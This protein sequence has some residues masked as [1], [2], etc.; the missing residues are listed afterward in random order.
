MRFKGG[1]SA[2][3][4][5]TASLAINPA[6][7]AGLKLALLSIQDDDLDLALKSVVS[8]I[9]RSPDMLCGDILGTLKSGADMKQGLFSVISEIYFSLGRQWDMGFQKHFSDSVPDTAFDVAL[10][11]WGSAPSSW[12]LDMMSRCLAPW[13]LQGELT[14]LML[15]GIKAGVLADRQMLEAAEAAFGYYDR[16]T[17]SMIV[18]GMKKR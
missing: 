17:A 18:S 16:E 6:S 12:A 11:A 2:K 3:D 9:R 14:P 7:I 10:M 5:Y 15:D 13:H 8:W 4:Y 1:Q